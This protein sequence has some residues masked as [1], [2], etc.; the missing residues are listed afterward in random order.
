[1]KIVTLYACFH[2]LVISEFVSH[3]ISQHL[4]VCGFVGFAA[5]IF[6]SASV[7]GEPEKFRKGFFLR[8]EDL[9]GCFLVLQ[10]KV[11]CTQR[12]YLF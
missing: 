11:F 6:K 1:M 9:L 5:V 7:L 10:N 2:E 3:L 12:S 8:Q 4:E